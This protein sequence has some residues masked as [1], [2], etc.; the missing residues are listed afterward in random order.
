MKGLP[1]RQDAYGH[2]LLDYL[3]QGESWTEIVERDD[4][5]VDSDVGPSGY[6]A[7]YRKWPAWEKQAMRSVRGRVLDVGTG[8][9]RVAL[10]LQER[11]H[12]VV[13]IDNS[14]LAIKVCLLRGVKDARVVPFT[15]VSRKLGVFESILRFATPWFDYLFVS[16]GE[17]RKI[18][19]GTGWRVV[20]TSEPAPVY[21]AVIEKES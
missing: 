2:G 20:S 3:V 8:A 6:F 10:H 11:G 13:A 18:V 1:Q 19:K 4:G 12:D 15:Q 14:P 17:M 5:I 21:V 7:E 9:G 16:P